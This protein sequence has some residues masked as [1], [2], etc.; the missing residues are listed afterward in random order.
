VNK[1]ECKRIGLQAIVKILLDQYEN[2]ENR[3]SL[4][5]SVP[6]LL[7]GSWHPFQIFS[8][9][10]ISANMRFTIGFGCI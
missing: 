10:N 4:W 3:D 8:L 5:S 6:N 9:Q 7:V 1:L 2:H